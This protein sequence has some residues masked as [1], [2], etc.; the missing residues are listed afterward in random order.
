MNNSKSF[1]ALPDVRYVLDRALFANIARI[2][3]KGNII[4]KDIWTK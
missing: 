1:M 4:S 2:K 3:N